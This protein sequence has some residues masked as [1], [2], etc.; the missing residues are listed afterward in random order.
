MMPDHNSAPV[1]ERPPLTAKQL[2]Y[3]LNDVVW[4]V[5]NKGQWPEKGRA[6]FLL[7]DFLRD[8]FYKDAPAQMVADLHTA[9]MQESFDHTIRYQWEEALEKHLAESDLVRERAEEIDR[10]GE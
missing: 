5:L 1:R 9:V 10:E 4:S 2:K 8:E 3:A 6:D 7:A